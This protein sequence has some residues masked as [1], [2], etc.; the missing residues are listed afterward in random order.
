M[1]NN[2]PAFNQG[3]QT[4]VVK[5]LTGDPDNLFRVLVTLTSASEE[6]TDVWARIANLYATNHAGMVFLPEVGDEVLISF[7]GGDE[8]QAVILGSLFGRTNKCL[9]AATENNAIKS[10]TTKNQLQINFDDNNKS[11]EIKTPDGNK[12]TI[13]DND[14]GIVIEDMNANSVQ[15]SSTGISLRSNGDINLDAKGSININANT[16]VKVKA[17]AGNIMLK[18][19]NIVNQANASFKA[20]GQAQAELS[21]SG[22]TVVKGAIVMIN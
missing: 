19:V 11:I 5:Q 12:I 21:A 3:L 18:G 16:N 4:G 6:I 9:V 17:D 14:G 8:E 2:S 10:I 1:S 20:T 15:L 7:I 22:Q 13:S